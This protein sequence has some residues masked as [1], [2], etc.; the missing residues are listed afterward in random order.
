MRRGQLRARSRLR[1]A[2]Y[3]ILVGGTDRESLIEGVLRRIDADVIA[4]QEV[5]NLQFV[6][7]LADRLHMEALVGEPSDP[8]PSCHIAILTRRSVRH[9]Q[10]RQ[11]VGQMLRSHLQCALETGWTDM[12]VIGVHCVHLAARFGERNKGEAR[13]MAELT[14]VLDGIAEQPALPHL[15]VGD[16]NSLAPGDEI[17]ATRFF[18]KFNELRRAGLLVALADGAIGP[19]PRTEA[20]AARI[21]AGWRSAG[22]DPRLEPGV[23]VLPRVVGPLTVNVPVSPAIDRLL[24]RFIER[25]TVDRLLRSGYV[26]AFRH[27]HPRAHGH[28]CATWLPAARVD[29]IFATPDLAR[30]LVA[31]DVVGDRR[32]PLPDAHVA[33]D[34]LPVVAD[35]V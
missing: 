19:A 4:M 13:R 23:P 16:F 11:H 27:I 12:P 29:Y 24:G 21:D 32:W 28:T 20:N 1:V 35:F 6:A 15:L 8:L 10:N 5:C 33:S 30:R 2:T 22:V 31:C 25:W 7:K 34:H 14:A 3:N 26:D 17:A 18:R 9:W